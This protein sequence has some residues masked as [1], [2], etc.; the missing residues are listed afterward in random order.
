M[1]QFSYLEDLPA[2]RRAAAWKIFRVLHGETGLL[3]NATTDRSDVRGCVLLLCPNVAS[4]LRDE[5]EEA[6]SSR[7]RK[8]IRACSVKPAY[9]GG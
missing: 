4:M 5:V 2:L 8:R 6:Q 9:L 1:R 3:Y 7:R